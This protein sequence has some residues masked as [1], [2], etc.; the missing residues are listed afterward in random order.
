MART[1]ATTISRGLLT[2]TMICIV[3]ME[4][5]I[6]DRDSLRIIDLARAMIKVLMAL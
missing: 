2:R 1:V 5:E 6:G 4:T 3:A